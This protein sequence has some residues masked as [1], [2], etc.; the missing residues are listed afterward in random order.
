M[1][2]LPLDFI[3]S[4]V[5]MFSPAL[6]HDSCVMFFLPD[7][8]VSVDPQ[9]ILCRNHDVLPGWSVSVRS[10]KPVHEIQAG[11]LGEF[12][13]IPS[14]SCVGM[15]FYQAGPFLSIPSWSCIG[16]TRLGL[17]QGRSFHSSVSRRKFPIRRWFNPRFEGTM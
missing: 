4:F 10:P 17:C 1:F 9:V 3:L 12:L 7:W 15:I 8:S 11:C 14:W 5:S 6:D 2:S 13:L 16:I